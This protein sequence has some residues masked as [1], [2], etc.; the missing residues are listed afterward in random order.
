MAK[1]DKALV[2]IALLALRTLRANAK[3]P[4]H[5][6]LWQLA[7]RRVMDTETGIEQDEEI[8]ALRRPIPRAP[9]ATL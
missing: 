6:D 9:A 4:R 7:I 3:S 5:G 2:D 8:A 1:P